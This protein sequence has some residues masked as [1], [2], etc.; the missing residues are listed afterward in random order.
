VGSFIYV[1]TIPC[2]LPL[3]EGCCEVCPGPWTIDAETSEA[4][5][6][7][8]FIVTPWFTIDPLKGPVGLEVTA[9][10][11]GFDADYVD[12]VFKAFP[13]D[14][15]V[16]EDVPVDEMG[17]FE[18]IFEVPEVIEGCYK[19]SA[20]GVM[21]TWVCE[22]LCFEVLPWIWIT[23]ESGNVGDTVTVI[24]KG[25][26][27]LRHVDIIYAGIADCPHFTLPFERV[28]G[29]HMALWFAWE[30]TPIC[31]YNAMIILQPWGWDLIAEALTDENGSFEVTF[32]VPESPGGYHP[33]YAGQCISTG[34]PSKLSE[35]VPVFRVEPK[36]WVEGHEGTSEGLSGEYVTLHGTGFSYVEF[37]L[38]MQCYPCRGFGFY[39][40]AGT[41]VL[42]F[43]SNKQWINEFNFIMNNKYD[44]GWQEMYWAWLKWIM[45]GCCT[46]C[47]LFP[48]G[49][50]PVYIDHSGTI[51]HGYWW[52][53]LWL[54]FYHEGYPCS[55]IFYD[56]LTYQ[57]CPF[58]EVPVL[59]PGEKELLAYYFGI[60][61]SL[62]FNFEDVDVMPL[63]FAPEGIV[64]GIPTMTVGAIEDPMSLLFGYGHA[65]FPVT[66]G[67]IYTETASTT[68]TIKK[69]EVES[70]SLAL[71][72]VLSRL[73][74]LE[75]KIT[76]VVEDAE[77]RILVR[78]DTTLGTVEADLSALDAKITSLVTDTEGKIL[79]EIETAAGTIQT[80][81]NNLDASITEIN[82]KLVTIDSSLGT[83][84]TDIS[85]VNGKLISL[86]GTL[87]TIE[88]SIGSF[89]ADLTDINTKITV[90][91]NNIAKIETDIGTIK[92]LVTAI[93]GN[94]ALIKTDI[95]DMK[96]TISEIKNDTGLQPATIGLSILAAISAIAAAV[97]I[98]RKVYLK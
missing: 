47:P 7:A 83:I 22:D 72:E 85:N 74:E 52:R 39:F 9:S 42:D 15:L 40:R 90:M 36:I 20:D 80:D 58:L 81:I 61:V 63:D 33:L 14:I 78:I 19:V 38:S 8:E 98:L 70:D 12:I 5:A 3:Q 17:N 93:D 89:T 48:E 43:D 56:D 37:W 1:F 57:G 91:N 60:E 87:A 32:E 86:E 50:L 68:F 65:E 41:F 77:G 54:L 11:Y 35:N 96:G 59:E 97:M 30:K 95:G 34:C 79:A 18:T 6:E 55:E 94:T 84:Q 25:W 4:Y 13:A 53:W 29:P 69:P 24:G 92:G 73:G 10:G 44:E 64:E 88:T 49:Y 76:D 67:K 2:D 21:A 75:A 51:S 62:S 23:P 82:G 66:L 28:T 45:D 71:E 31:C 26:D 16:K 46:P 27:S